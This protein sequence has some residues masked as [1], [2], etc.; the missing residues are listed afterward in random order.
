MDKAWNWCIEFWVR[1]QGAYKVGKKKAQ[2]TAKNTWKEGKVFRFPTI[3]SSLKGR[4]QGAGG[5]WEGTVLT[6]EP[7]TLW[8]PD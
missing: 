8:A 5:L 2:K 4:D 3:L 6:T 1:K 7:I